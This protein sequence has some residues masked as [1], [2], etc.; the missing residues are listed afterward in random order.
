MRQTQLAVDQDTRNPPG[1]SSQEQAQPVVEHGQV[2]VGGTHEDGPSHQDL[3][4]G[5]SLH[6]NMPPEC[7]QQW[8]S[9]G[10]GKGASHQNWQDDGPK[11]SILAQTITATQVRVM[12]DIAAENDSPARR[13][14]QENAD[15]QHPSIRQVQVSIGEPI[16]ASQDLPIGDEASG[17]IITSMATTQASARTGGLDQPTA[18]THILQ[19]SASEKMKL[20][21]AKIL[22]IGAAVN[23]ISLVR[24]MVRDADNVPVSI[25]SEGKQEK[26]KPGTEADASPRHQALPSSATQDQSSQ[27]GQYEPKWVAVC[28]A[29]ADRPRPNAA[30]ADGAKAAAVPCTQ[31]A[32]TIQPAASP[33]E[34]AE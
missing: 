4:C 30:P 32:V 33:A 9:E 16:N 6:T 5:D 31:S 22:P 7:T 25:Q 15:S 13:I 14:V 23:H 29:D 21:T 3:S 28:K 27:G 8:R 10:A 34:E 11:G 18:S 17:D 12:G 20:D 24:K 19:V 2:V 1:H 26:V